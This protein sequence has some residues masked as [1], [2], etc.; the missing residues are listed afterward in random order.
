MTTFLRVIIVKWQ[1]IVKP[2]K[3]EYSAV[4]KSM[5]LVKILYIHALIS[6]SRLVRSVS[7][8]S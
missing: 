5:D 1:N 3:S 2:E 8:M 6:L 7:I 4:M